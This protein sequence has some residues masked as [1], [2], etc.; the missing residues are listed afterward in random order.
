MADQPQYTYNSFKR[1]P[2]ISSD[3]MLSEA[4][5]SALG[6]T[7]IRYPAND[8]DRCVEGRTVDEV[9]TLILDGSEDLY[10]RARMHLESQEPWVLTTLYSSLHAYDL[11]LHATILEF[12][13][14]ESDATKSASVQ[15]DLR[16]VALTKA[17]YWIE[18]HYLSPS[19]AETAWNRYQ[20]T[21]S[22]R[23]ARRRRLRTDTTK[24]P[25]HS[26]ETVTEWTC[27]YQLFD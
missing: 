21:A 26:T 16:A 24:L 11:E 25:T 3:D 20:R 27:S 10:P 14:E 1:S 18:Y 4:T 22:Q 9:V 12:L 7:G 2:S 23:A 19:K 13:L 5:S 6:L 8:E 17:F 15:E